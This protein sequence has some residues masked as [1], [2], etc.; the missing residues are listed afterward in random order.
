[1]G[2]INAHSD[3][4]YTR[5]VIG[6]SIPSDERLYLLVA[7]SVYCAI[8]EVINED[9]KISLKTAKYCPF[10]MNMESAEQV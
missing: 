2:E 7:G 10:H 8:I 1:M 3:L 9:D 6:H 4:V 5:D